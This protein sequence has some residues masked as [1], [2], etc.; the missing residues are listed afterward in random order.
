MFLTE[1][2]CIFGGFFQSCTMALTSLL[3][4]KQ[5]S[6]WLHVQLCIEKSE[7]KE[8][9]KISYQDYLVYNSVLSTVYNNIV[10][11]PIT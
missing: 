1:M 4:L 2:Y 9:L 5:Q 10:Y 7:I 6:S 3:T 11:Q 8:K